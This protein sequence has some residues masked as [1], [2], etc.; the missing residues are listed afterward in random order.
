MTAKDRK[1]RVLLLAEACNPE[2]SS[3]PLLAYFWYRAL[4]PHADVTLATQ[5]RNKPGFDRNGCAGENVVFI[6]SEWMAAE[7][8][9]VQ[10]SYD[11]ERGEV[12][13][14]PRPSR[15]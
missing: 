11:G 8:P 5:S 9:A 10:V 1:I 3:V 4:L 15:P 12:R 2:W 13:K 7:R 14:R 6:D